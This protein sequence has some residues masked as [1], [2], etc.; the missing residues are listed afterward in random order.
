ML[1]HNKLKFDNKPEN[2]VDF[3]GTKI[4]FFAIRYC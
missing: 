4:L 2:A 3:A 1:F